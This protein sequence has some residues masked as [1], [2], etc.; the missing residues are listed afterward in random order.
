MSAIM[1]FR[2][3]HFKQRNVKSHPESREVGIEGRLPGAARPAPG[4]A[5][6]WAECSPPQAHGR[7][8]VG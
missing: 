4:P 2:K 8:P 1:K 5:E 7:T 6:W 3:C